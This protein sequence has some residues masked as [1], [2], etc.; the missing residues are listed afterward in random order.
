MNRNDGNVYQRFA[1]YHK[2]FPPP[3]SD[4]IFPLNILEMIVQQLRGTILDIGTANGFKLGNLLKHAKSSEIRK[5]LALE[6]SPVLCEQARERFKDNNRVEIYNIAFDD[7]NLSLSSFDVILMFEVLEHLPNQDE[8]LQKI[9]Q[10]IKPGGIFIGS[11]PNKWVY[12]ITSYLV[13]KNPDPT[14]ISELTYR[15]AIRML[16]K[17]FDQCEFAGFIPCM[18]LYRKFPQL[19][20]INRYFNLLF[21][22]RSV[23][24]FAKNPTS[25]YKSL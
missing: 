8:V 18:A 25:E 9:S 10:I 11:T 14:H 13:G 1:E 2:V 7:S 6:P 4:I 22:T 5:I 15:E 19:S 24:F 17:Y 12:R 23:Y 21:I 3:I 20:R 16:T